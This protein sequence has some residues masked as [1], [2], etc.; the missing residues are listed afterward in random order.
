MLSNSQKNFIQTSLKQLN[1]DFEWDN[2]I[3]ISGGCINECYKISSK[4]NLHF[5]L[6]INSVAHIDNLEKEKFNL[7][8]LKDKSSLKIPNF[9]GLFHD[10]N[11]VYLVLEYLERIPENNDFYYQ[12]G[13]GLAQLHQNTEKFFGWFHDNYIGSLHQA[14]HQHSNWSEF[15]IVERLEPLTKICFDQNM[16]GKSDIKAFQNLYNNIENIFP[17]E[18]P[19]LLHGDLWQGNRMNSTQGVAIFDPACYYGHREM[20]IS[21]CFLFGNLPPIFFEAYN[22]IHPLEKDFMKRKDICNLYPL[23]VHAILFGMSYIYD[24]KSII[25]K[26]Q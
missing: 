14:N 3:N 11:H 10:D 6:K 15:F 2:T 5:F 13:I 24:I 1:P 20:D 19:A 25:K 21:M 12:F 4:N 9:I 26:F 8:Y 18:H 7:K 17:S 23:L 22:S 16:L